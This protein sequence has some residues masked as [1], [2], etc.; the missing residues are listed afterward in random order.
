MNTKRTA[1]IASII[2]SGIVFLDSTIVNVALPSIRASLHGGLAEQ[3]WV[4]EAYL[5]T[6]S[7]LLLVGGSLGDLFGRRRVFAIGLAGFGFCSALCA[8]APTGTFLIG[9]RALQGA[10]GA[11]LV[12]STLALIVDTF[13]EDERAGAIG[14]WTAFTGVATVIGPLGGGA[15]VQAASWRW[16][17]A[18]NLPLVAITLLLLSRL[19]S[20]RRTPGHVDVPGAILCALGLG[21]PVFALIEQPGRG[22]TDPLVL[23]PLVG[24]IILLAAFIAWERRCSHPMVPLHLF[25]VRNFAIGNLTTLSLYA[26]LGVAT[27]FLILFLQQVGGYTPLQAGM[28]L[29]PIT[30]LVFLLSK[31]FGMLADRIGP[32]VFMAGGPILAGLGLLALVRTDA[33]AD[34]LTQI[35][36]GILVFGLGLA[37]T[38]APLTATVLSSVP[39]GHSG[40]A[41]GVNNAVARVAS[42]LAIAALG[43]VVSAAFIARVDQDLTSTPLGAPARAAVIQAK[44]RPLVTTVPGT[45]R[46]T[47]RADIHATLVD[48][49]VHAFRIGIAVAA[50]LALLGGLIALVGIVNPRQRVR[51]ADCPGGALTGAPAEE[52]SEPVPAGA[53]SRR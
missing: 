47:A 32:R 48:A 8:I 40:L 14:T 53:S 34:Y 35:L 36:P 43:A 10:F 5:L 6:L 52:P 51:S 18:I 33:S 11:L 12:P 3:Q 49:S 21:G 20:D 44:H 30:L 31:R 42:L 2:G 27:F 26:G 7:S 24:G 29:L 45:V 9:A 39:A 25:T 15:L 13:S 38:V 28:S 37:A 22:W 46:G 50:A 4:V 1:L 17:F 16:I 23:I 19:P 41:S